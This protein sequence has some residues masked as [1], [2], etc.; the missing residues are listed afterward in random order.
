MLGSGSAAFNPRPARPPVDETKLSTTW[1]HRFAFFRAYGSP[2][3]QNGLKALKQLP[4]GTSTSIRRNF[5]ALFFGP[6]YF[7]IL[8][9]WKRGISLLGFCLVLNVVLDR[10]FGDEV[11]RG[12]SCGR[13]HHLRSRRQLLLLHQGHSRPRRVEPASRSLLQPGLAYVGH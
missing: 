9:L 3:S 4:F 11:L 8:G 5:W 2:Y 12:L 6:I 10:L 13:G 7:A 1:Q